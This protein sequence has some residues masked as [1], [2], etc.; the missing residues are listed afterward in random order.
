MAA[1]FSDDIFN[2]IFFNEMCR[3]L[4]SI[5]LK[6]VAKGSMDNKPALVQIM[7][8]RRPGDKALSYAM[9][10]SLLKH[11]RVVDELIPQLFLPLVYIYRE[12]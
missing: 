11:I 3:I 6:Y 4:I 1:I 7:A 2:L 12:N 5:S 10:V 9:I 8:W